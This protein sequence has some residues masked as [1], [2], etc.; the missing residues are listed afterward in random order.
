MHIQNCSS[1]PECALN[2]FPKNMHDPMGIKKIPT[3]TGDNTSK[4]YDISV[5]IVKS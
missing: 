4:K 3:F 2:S 5:G 1:E